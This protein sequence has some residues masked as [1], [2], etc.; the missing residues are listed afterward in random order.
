MTFDYDPVA[1]E[2]DRYCRGD[3]L[4]REWLVEEKAREMRA[5][6]DYIRDAATEKAIEAAEGLG[7]EVFAA[8]YA[9]NAKHPDD[10]AGSQVLT[11]LYQVAKQ[12]AAAIDEQIG[13]YAEWAIDREDAA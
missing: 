4:C 9:L 11:D 7:G 6:P 5:D 12:V 13:Q 1:A 10:L 8:L 3:S 2:V